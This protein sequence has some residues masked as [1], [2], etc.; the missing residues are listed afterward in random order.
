MKFLCLALALAFAVSAA[1]DAPEAQKT[2]AP[3]DT[4]RVGTFNIR[5]IRDLPP[6]SWNLRFPRVAKV[7]A[8]EQVKKS[9]KLL[10]LQLEVGT[11][12]RQVVSGIHPWYEPQDLIGKQV[13]LAYNLTPAKLRGVESNGMILAATV[14]DRAQVVF[15]DEQIP[16]GSKL[17]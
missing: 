6:N 7:L 9:D 16:S 2:A 5:L 11:E 15:V 3:A 1:A 8:C 14:G 17:S 12:K 10:C 4:L 13:L